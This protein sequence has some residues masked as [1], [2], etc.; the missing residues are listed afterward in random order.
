MRFFTMH[1]QVKNHR[2]NNPLQVSGD[3]ESQVHRIIYTLHLQVGHLGQRSLM[4]FFHTSRLD[5][6]NQMD[7]CKSAA[8][9]TRRG[10]CKSAA[11]RTRRGLCKSAAPRTRRGLCN[12][13][14]VALP[15]KFF[16][17]KVRILSRGTLTKLHSLRARRSSVL[18]CSCSLVGSQPGMKRKQVGS[19]ISHMD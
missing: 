16:S 5:I 8:L 4:Y 12:C 9:R 19:T 18:Q 14:S 11:P 2:K 6:L 13:K 3:A 15:L 17:C 10:L 1:L 7:L